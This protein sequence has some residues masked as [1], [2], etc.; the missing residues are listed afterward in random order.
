MREVCVEGVCG[1]EGAA[2]TCNPAWFPPKHNRNYELKTLRRKAS[3]RS[4]G[5]GT[6]EHY[7]ERKAESTG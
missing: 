7:L 3:G 5:V 2:Y 1:R 6:G 4:D